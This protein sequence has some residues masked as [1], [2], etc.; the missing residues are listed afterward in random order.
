[1]NTPDLSRLTIDRGASGAAGRNRPAGGGSK[2]T[3]LVLLLLLG[4]IGWNE[5]GRPEIGPELPRVKV[6]RVAKVGGALPRS[7]VSANGYVVPRTRAA[8]STDIPG[9]LVE[10]RV[11]EGSRVSKGELVARLDTRELEASRQRTAADLQRTEALVTLAELEL[12][13]IEALV[14]S[15]DATPAD[16][17]RARADLD[18]ARAQR[19]GTRAILDEIEVRIDKSSVYAPFDGIV[20]EKNAEVGEI[21]S[22]VGAGANSRGAVATLVDF[23]SLEVQVELAQSSLAAA[24]EGAPVRIELDAWKDRSYPGRV[25]QVWP[26]ADRQKA[27]VELRAVF[28]ERD[29]RIL[30]ELGVRVTFIADEE[31]GGAPPRILLPAGALTPGPEAAVFIYE[32]GVAR[33]RAVLTERAEEPGFLRVLRGLSGGELVIE[34]PPAGLLDGDQVERKEP[35]S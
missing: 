11:E 6:S 13:R 12:G 21:V 31:L 1:M 10:L 26:T 14:E 16:R 27:T 7:G 18:V 28:L 4:Y 22:S 29:E 33:R 30:P 8:L 24:R 17:D 15:G 19:E 23:E 34:S 35:T 5:F 9:R 3:L 2:L 32:D 25:R 20:V